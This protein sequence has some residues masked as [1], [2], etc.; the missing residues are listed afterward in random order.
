MGPKR[1]L[2]YE[3]DG[4]KQSRVERRCAELDALRQQ[5]LLTLQEVTEYFTLVTSL[6]Q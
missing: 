4:E 5:R 1:N 2:D 6:Y 3:T